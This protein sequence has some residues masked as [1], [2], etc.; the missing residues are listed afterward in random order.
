V[1]LRTAELENS[2]RELEAFSYSVSHDLRAPLRAIDG[3]AHIIEEDY[4]QTIGPTGQAYL[5]RIRKATHR[6]AELIDNLI[7]LARLTRQTP[8]RQQVDV[9]ELV[10]Q[11]VDELRAEMPERQMALRLEPGLTADA[12][13]ALLRALLENLLR[14]AWKFTARTEHPTVSVTAKEV[15][16]KQVYCIADNGVGFDM[17]FANKLFRPFHRLH[18]QTEFAGTGIG[19]A[20]VDRIIQR[21]GGSVWAESE[22]GKGARFYFTL[23]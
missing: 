20:T 1:Q 22:V 7:E 14:N 6:M 5:T 4:G 19:L 21:H 23:G 11:I 10:T 8:H 12:D 15:D 2:N 18:D 17:A 16:D 13:R 3:F 9:S